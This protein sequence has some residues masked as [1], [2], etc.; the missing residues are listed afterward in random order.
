[1]PMLLWKKQKV[2]ILDEG[3]GIRKQLD[4]MLDEF[5]KQKGYKS[6]TEISADELKVLSEE[7][8]KNVKSVLGKTFP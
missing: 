5:K 2:L 3:K 8:K 4:E 1:M 6:D 7:F